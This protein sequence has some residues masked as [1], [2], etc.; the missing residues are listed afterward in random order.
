MEVQSHVKPVEVFLIAAPGLVLLGTLL[1]RTVRALWS[2]VFKQPSRSSV[3]LKVGDDVITITGASDAETKSLI[4]KYMEANDTRQ[5][6][7]PAAG[8]SK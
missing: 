4:E 8:E 6:P 1:S 2:S 5:T 7:K 3:M